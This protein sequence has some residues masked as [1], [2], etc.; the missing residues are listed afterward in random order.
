MAINSEFLTV[1]SEM[2]IVP[3]K[4]CRIPTLTVSPPVA[5]GDAAAEDAAADDAGADDELPASLLLLLPQPANT[6][7]AVN[8]RTNPFNPL[9]FFILPLPDL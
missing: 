9:P 7:L 2:D 1:T 4:E 6:K 8:A 5:A 3:L